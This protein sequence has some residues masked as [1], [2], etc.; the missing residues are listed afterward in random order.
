MSKD[1]IEKLE[2]NYELYT[3][4]VGKIKNEDAREALLGLCNEL[5]DRLA[6]APAST[7]LDYVGAYPGGLVEHSINVL[8]IAKDLNKVFA[9]NIQSDSLIITSLFHDI[10]KV[11]DEKNDFYIEQPSDWHRNKLGMMYDFNEEVGRI[12]V[13]QRSLWWLNN[14]GCPLSAEE[15]SAISSLHHVGQMWSSELYESPMLSVILQTAVRVACMKGKGKESI[16]A[17]GK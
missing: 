10:G 1:L 13:S 6:A 3:T 16:L 17:D 11:G 4:L 5:K 2:K 14:S 7:K 15:I 12:P 9:A 8:R